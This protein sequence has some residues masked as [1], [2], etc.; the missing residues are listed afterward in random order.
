MMPSYA[1]VVRNGKEVKI[2]AEEIVPGDIMILEEGDRY[3]QGMQEFCVVVFS[4]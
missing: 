4:S 2:L 3:L 1:R